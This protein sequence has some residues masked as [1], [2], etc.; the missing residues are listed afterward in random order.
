MRFPKKSL[1][2]L[3]NLGF[4]ATLAVVLTACGTEPSQTDPEAGQGAASDPTPVA[5]QV[6]EVVD[7]SSVGSVT[8]R[9]DGEE[10]SFDY[11][12]KSSSLY[13][14][15]ASSMWAYPESGSTQSVAIHFMS[16][17]L[18][19]L[20][21]PTELPLPK[22]LTKPMDPMAAMA[23][24]GFGYIDA[25]GVEWAGP[26]KIRVEAFGNDGV[27]R[28]TFDQVALPHT[29]NERPDIMLTNGSFSA[30]IASPW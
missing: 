5:Q 1:L 6:K 28:G 27:I 14:P 9:V 7:E 12:P 21:Y 30:R 11:V 2:S 15:I 10:K 18:K 23:S 25:E 3:R 13:N 22:D 8:F 29:D 26:G 19:K 24:V 16:I 17:D 4:S 20:T